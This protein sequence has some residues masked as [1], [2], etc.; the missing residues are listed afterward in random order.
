MHT[1]Q[2]E[3]NHSFFFFVR[4]LDW[5][6]QFFYLLI[7]CSHHHHHHHHHRNGR[8]K[9]HKRKILVHDL[10]KQVVK[11]NYNNG[12]DCL[13]ILMQIAFQSL[14]AHS[15]HTPESVL[16]DSNNIFNGNYH[17]LL[18]FLLHF[19]FLRLLTFSF[20]LFYFFNIFSL[21]GCRSRWT[22]ETSEMDNHCN[23]IP[24]IIDVSS[25]GRCNFAYGTSYRWYG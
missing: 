3:C 21:L 10:D 16:I 25:I 7:N 1:V 11:V 14:A 6:A 8:K 18:P 23:C 4:L 12:L 24:F 5:I 20:F 22:V 17:L 19:S 9:R 15:V 13:N 2:H